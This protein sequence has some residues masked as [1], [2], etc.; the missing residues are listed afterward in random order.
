MAKKERKQKEIVFSEEIDSRISG[1]TLGFAFIAIGLFLLFVPDYFGNKLAGQIIRWVFIVVGTLGLC[2]EFGKI[3]PISDIKG[4]NDLWAGVLL[5][6][7][8]AVLFLLLKNSL[9]NIVG[10]FC[11]IVGVYGTFLG[12]LRIIYSIQQN[13]KNKVQSK[14]TILSDILV[15]FTKVASLALVALQLIRAVQN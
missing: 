7:V 3:K 13:Q 10:F 11:L 12:L 4:F 5:L 9:W 8:W 14:G 1:L 6:S 15:F 2:V